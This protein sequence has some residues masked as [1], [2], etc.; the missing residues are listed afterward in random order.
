[1]GNVVEE[2]SRN[3]EGKERAALSVSGIQ[4]KGWSIWL[5]MQQPTGSSLAD[6][7]QVM[8]PLA[9]LVAAAD[10]DCVAP[11]PWLPQRE[12]PQHAQSVLAP[13]PVKRTDQLLPRRLNPL[14]PLLHCSGVAARL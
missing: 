14:M 2:G 3:G 4:S 7:P 11:R 12:G 8:K 5:M 6:S 9:L 1:M 10:Q 13:T